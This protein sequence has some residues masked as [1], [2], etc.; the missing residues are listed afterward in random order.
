MDG[1]NGRIGVTEWGVVFAV[2]EDTA[3]KP[4]PV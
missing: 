4:L 1:G 3:N 2:L